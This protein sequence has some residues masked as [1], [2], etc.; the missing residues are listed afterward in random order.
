M[1]RDAKTSK[2]AQKKESSEKAGLKFVVDA[3]EP[4]VRGAMPFKDLDAFASEVVEFS[5]DLIKHNLDDA[6]ASILTLLEAVTTES[7]THL[8]SEVSF[9]LA[10]DASGELAILSMAKGALKGSAGIQV[11]IS[12]K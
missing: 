2:P 4:V 5:S 3:P 11:V 6:L 8:V 12:R 10:F 9:S 1:A 7:K